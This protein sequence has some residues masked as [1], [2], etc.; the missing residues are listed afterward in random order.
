MHRQRVLQLYKTI[1]RLHRALPTE[2]QELGNQYVRDEFRRHK[3]IAPE[4]VAPFM[5]EWAQYCSSLAEQVGLKGPKSA[6]RLGRSLGEEKLDHFE[7][8]QIYQL[9]ELK[10]SIEG[11]AAGSDSKSSK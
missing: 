1:L 11:G 8:Q 3:G 9:Y 6:Q 5:M 7:P 10:Q 4:H 2:L